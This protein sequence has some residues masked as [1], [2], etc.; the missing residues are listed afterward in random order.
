MK[1]TTP[2]II[3]VSRQLG[4][5]GAT[6]GQEVAAKLNIRYVD[7]EII[8]RAAQQLS[9]M[10]EELDEREERL[11][12][13]WKSFFQFNIPPAD[14]PVFA[15]VR[16][17]SSGELFRVEREIIEHIATEQS[18]VIM[19]R[20]GYQ[21]LR[22]HP[23]RVS[24]YLHADEGYRTDRLANRLNIKEKEARKMIEKN[25]KERTLYI[26]TF[27]EDKWSDA[28]HFDLCIDTGRTGIEQ[29]VAL[30]LQYV[31]LVHPSF[32]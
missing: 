22:S 5:G 7:Q 9:V 14:V 26:E 27:T 2:L 1:E 23:R 3:T 19:G 15:N 13:F 12:S 28:R 31:K 11:Q 17:T 25:D 16:L 29:S 10:E 21:V 18:S 20:C 32:G 30:I 6:I 24:V 8:S 4:S